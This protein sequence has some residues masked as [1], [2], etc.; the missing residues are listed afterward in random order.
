MYTKELKHI[1]NNYNLTCHINTPTRKRTCIDQIASNIRSACGQTHE[2]A[3]SDHNTG[4]TMTFEIKQKIIPT[5]CW[6]QTQRDF[7][8]ENMKK[9][10]NA[11][12][13]L[14]FSEVYEKTSTDEA[15]NSFHDLLS[16]FYN[17]CFPKTKIKFNQ[18]KM[19]SKWITKGVKTCTKT[20]RKLYYEYQKSR[21]NKL[22]HK[23]KYISYSN[24][25]KKCV[26]NAKRNFSNK[27]L[28]KADNKCRATWKLINNNI[29]IQPIKNPIEKIITEDQIITDPQQICNKFNE[30]YI[31]L[32][33]NKNNSD[34]SSD[35]MNIVSNSM[36]LMPT[37]DA[38]IEKIIMSLRNSSSTGYDDICTKTL[39]LCAKELSRPLS[40]IIN[41]SLLEGKF[42]DKLKISLVKPIFKKGNEYDI[43]NYRPVTLIPVLS[44]VFEKAM[45]S[46]VLSFIN[47]NNILCK[48]QFGFRKHSST[49]L[50]CF[51]LLKHITE[52]LNEKIRVTVVFLDLSKAFDFVNHK[53][54]LHKLQCYGIRGHC[55][56]WFKS[57]LDER[58][59]CVEIAKIIGN[60]KEN[61]QS[62]FKYNNAGVPQGS[63]LGPLLFLLYINELPNISKHETILFADDTTIV[64]KCENPDTYEYEINSTL[65]KFIEW[66]KNNDLS[67]NIS[68][69]NMI[70]FQTYNSNPDKINIMYESNQI[71]EI[72]NTKFLGLIIDK[73]CNW[74]AHIEQVI[75]KV[76][77]F[78]YALRNLRQVVSKDAALTAYHGYVASVLAYG[79]LLWGR[80]TDIFKV[81]RIQKK[82]IRAIVGIRNDES[83][84]PFFKSLKVLTIF[85]MYIKEVC[86]FVREHMDLFKKQSDT[87]ER[88]RRDPYK[89][90]LPKIRV[91][92]YKHNAYVMCIRIYNKLPIEYK[93]LPYKKF[94]CEL[95]KWLLNKCF[96]SLDEYMMA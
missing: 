85:S 45:Y 93:S 12:A 94:K 9:F 51:T 72:N 43:H 55:Q 60:H 61:V 58:L 3:L 26:H 64:F 40:Y 7:N 22:A 23:T 66:L 56:K 79:L 83:C 32:T 50:A 35:P 21:Q 90:T 82:C 63:V 15:F 71:E 52:C 31:S 5:T 75:N 34:I 25:L 4:Q 37:D 96:Y 89:L 16:L 1:L 74:K 62:D 81:F 33:N 78:I 57:Y 46:R 18:Q 19:R 54:L 48:Q 14:S 28:N 20:K 88:S 77:K 80:S 68:K 47:R 27:Y 70:Q 49:T 65:H 59:Q 13:A 87:N 36:F 44:K 39:K 76:G 10:R 38:E 6:T 91:D 86:V 2:L 67:I 53:K 42:P 30:F 8:K 84:K 29:D 69:T 92:V 24:M 17:L 95:T 11:I 73:H 41:L